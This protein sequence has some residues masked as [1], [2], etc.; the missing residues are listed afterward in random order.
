MAES[1]GVLASTLLY[2]CEV[3]VCQE[4]HK[5]KMPEENRALRLKESAAPMPQQVLL[6]P[7]D[8]SS[9]P[10]P[11]AS[12]APASSAPAPLAS[13]ADPRVTWNYFDE[14]RYVERG[15]L[16]PGEDPYTRNRFNQDASDRLASNRDIPDERHP[17]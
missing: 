8:T 11:P 12:S 5:S 17:M 16:R 4:K 10:L 3:W 1:R 2:G 9:A 13:D 7:E 6:T 14:R 15:G